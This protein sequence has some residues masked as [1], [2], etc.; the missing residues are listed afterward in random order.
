MDH[1]TISVII[2]C[3]N[4]GRFLPDAVASLF[5]GDSVLGPLPGQTIANETEAIIVNDGSTDSAAQIS[6]DLASRLDGRLRILH[7]DGPLGTS[8]A[9]NAGIRQARGEFIAILHADDM[10]ESARLERLLTM[11]RANPQRV[12]Y[13]DIRVVFGDRRERI[14]PMSDYDFNLVVKKNIVHGGIFFPRV[15]WEVVGGYPEIMTRGRE[16]WAFNVLLGS[17]GWCGV[18]VPEP[19]YLYRRHDNNRT[20]SNGGTDWQGFF[21][22]Q[23]M[24][25][26]PGIMRGERP[27]GC[28]GSGNQNGSQSNSPP[29]PLAPGAE[30]FTILEYIGSNSGNQTWYGPATGARYTLGGVTRFAYVDNRDVS[31]MTGWQEGGRSIFRVST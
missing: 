15:A 17:Q 6:A 7:L 26:F 20:L 13:D 22:Q 3:H 14:I 16:D 23:M 19:G 11:A 9:N 5:G 12:I 25:L 31:G 29:Q 30:G 18:R 28:C 8:A 27:M 2:P 4:Y 21:F 24:G 10:M 1:P